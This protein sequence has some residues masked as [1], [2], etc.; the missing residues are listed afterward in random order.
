MS[1]SSCS[2][3]FRDVGENRR[4]KT[5]GARSVEALL[6]QLVDPVHLGRSGRFSDLGRRRRLR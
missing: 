4:R 6:L 3:F 5:S 2:S 1:R